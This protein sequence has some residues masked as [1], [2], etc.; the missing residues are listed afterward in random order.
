MAL[1]GVVPALGTPVGDGDRVDVPGLR[2]LVR[3]VLNGGVHA[4][5]ANGSM[6]G[7]AFLTNAEQLRSI[8][9]TVEEVDGAV[10]VIG[11]LGETGTSRAVAH[12]R[13]IVRRGTSA[14]GQLAIHAEALA[15][16]RSR[17]EAQRAVVDWL[18]EESVAGL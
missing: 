12:A 18:I 1:R 17:E 11:G 7:F 2:R 16:G 9:T 15:A 4:L 14:H 6:G 8:S 5:L 3:H 13:D 10:P